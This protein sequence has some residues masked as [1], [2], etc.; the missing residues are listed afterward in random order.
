[1]NL[2]SDD[3]ENKF[4]ETIKYM[5]V[6]CTTSIDEPI[7]QHFSDGVCADICLKIDGFDIHH[8]DVV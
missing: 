8:C 1:V 5:D 4:S 3:V 7:D 6:A 2:V